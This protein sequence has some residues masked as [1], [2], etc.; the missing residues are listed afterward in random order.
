MEKMEVTIRPMAEEDYNFVIQSWLKSYKHNSYFCKRI[1]DNIY[2]KYHHQVIT[3]ILA[4]DNCKVLIAADPED[5]K[6]ILGYLVYESFQGKELVHYA[7]IK[8]SFRGL[9]IGGA[10]LRSS[11]INP[12]ESL[13]SHW[14]KDTDGLIEKYKGATY[15]PYLI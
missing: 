10:L 3:R 12:F 13:F 14:T 4:R 6:V 7:Y 11:T 2:Y 5:S 8:T 9:G 15:V 1:R